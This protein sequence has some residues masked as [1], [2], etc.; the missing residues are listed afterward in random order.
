MIAIP[1]KPAANEE[2][3]EFMANSDPLALCHIVYWRKN[4]GEKR[5]YLWQ[6]ATSLCYTMYIERIREK[7]ISMA[8]NCAWL[9]LGISEKR[10]AIY[11][12]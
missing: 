1:S 3:R 4:I 9:Y 7:K 10:K 6:T 2:E 5:G 8:G 11:I 12:K